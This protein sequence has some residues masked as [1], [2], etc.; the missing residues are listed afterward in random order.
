MISVLVDNKIPWK[1][2]WV[3]VLRVT[4]TMRW[5]TRSDVIKAN[6]SIAYFHMFSLPTL[7]SHHHIRAAE[8]HSELFS[9]NKHIYWRNYY[10][11]LMFIF[12]SMMHDGDCGVSREKERKKSQTHK[13]EPLDTYMCTH[14]HS[15]IHNVVFSLK[16]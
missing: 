13:S 14:R 9:I 2:H 7:L 11:S 3:L 10:F 6:G 16:K 4:T 15:R 8:W 12:V 5:V 1:T